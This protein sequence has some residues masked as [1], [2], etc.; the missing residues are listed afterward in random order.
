[1]IMHTLLEKTEYQKVLALM[2]WMPEDPMMHTVLE[3]HQAGQV[4]V[5]NPDHPNA[6][7]IWSGM[8]YA[9]LIGSGAENFIPDVRPYIE[10]TILPALQNAGLGFVSI[11]PEGQSSRQAL[12]S[13]FSHR[14]PTSYRVDHYTFSTDKYQQQIKTMRPL[15]EE[16]TLVKLD[17]EQLAKPAFQSTREDL[18]FCWESID[19]FLE[20][21]LG[22]TVLC[23]GQVAGTCYAIAFGAGAYHI[24]IWTAPQHRRRG[25]AQRTAAALIDEALASGKT[26]Y[27]L[28]DTPNTASHRLA[29]SVGFIFAGQLYPVDIPAEPGPFHRG[30]ARHFFNYLE[31]YR[32]AERLYKISLA[33][34]PEDADAVAGLALIQAQR[35]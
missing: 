21:G 6:A 33:F 3:G 9:Y 12:L 20:L 2:E 15:K 27:W 29:E 4:L 7:L 24:N 16:Y 13:E 17:R 10:D 34:N 35:S 8:E 22:W 11:F 26:V 19:R 14:S 1:M 30:L 23:E 32:E 31:D 28:N 18:E 25:L 5:D